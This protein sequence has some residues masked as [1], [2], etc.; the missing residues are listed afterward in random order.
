MNF[1]EIIVSGDVAEITYKP[2]SKNDKGLQFLKRIKKMHDSAVKEAK[3]HKR[4]I[5]KTT[6]EI[7]NS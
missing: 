6:I 4:K 2:K 5:P 3:K 7:I 1:K